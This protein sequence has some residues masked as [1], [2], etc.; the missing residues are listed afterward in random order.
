MKQLRMNFCNPGEDTIVLTGFRPDPVMGGVWQIPR[1]PNE[2]LN[3]NGLDQ[4]FMDIDKMEELYQ[5]GE[6][7]AGA[8][9]EEKKAKMMM[10]QLQAMKSSSGGK[11][12]MKQIQKLQE[13]G[14]QI[15]ALGTDS[16][17][18]AM[19]QFDFP[20]EIKNKDN[21]LVKKVVNAQET[22][23]KAASVISY[24]YYRVT[25]EFK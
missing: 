12:D 11:M 10:A 23:P 7:A 2:L 1:A 13:M 20:L 5:S 3:I 4:N 19:L 8:A 15:T 21:I 24:G 25:I 18:A 14:S 16:R 6:A 9:D 17:V 22:N